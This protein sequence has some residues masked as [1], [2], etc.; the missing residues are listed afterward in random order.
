MSIPAVLHAAGLRLPISDSWAGPQLD[1]AG[2]LEPLA[3][4]VNHWIHGKLPD[5]LAGVERGEEVSHRG[6]Y[7][8][9]ATAE[10]V[11]EERAAIWRALGG[12]DLGD[13]PVLV[14]SPMTYEA[15][16]IRRA[17]LV[18]IL[19]AVARLRT[20]AARRPRLPSAVTPGEPAPA[21]QLFTRTPT[22]QPPSEHERAALGA[23]EDLAVAIDAAEA[24]ASSDAARDAIAVRRRVLLDML[25][26]QGVLDEARAP[27]KRAFLEGFRLPALRD[28]LDAATALR[29]YH[30]SPARAALDLGPP[31]PRVLEGAVSLDWFRAPSPPPPGV[32]AQ[33]WLA[34]TERAL[35]DAPHDGPAGE[36]TARA[37]DH[38]YRVRWRRDHDRPAV[39]AAVAAPD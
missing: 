39:V 21:P 8:V 6:F 23:A 3:W 32:S 37:A 5:L 7:A 11:T 13:D 18:E 10:D 16:V 27:E 25:D 20:E 4:T 28:Y 33:T 26:A 34:I 30:R 2:P 14:G 15:F 29:A 17:A 38:R 9:R 24:V 19:R 36:I 35:R 31:P 1:V 12:D 22:D